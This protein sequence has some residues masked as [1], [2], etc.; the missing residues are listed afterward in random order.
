[1]SRSRSKF[2]DSFYN[3]VHRPSCTLDT[4]PPRSSPWIAAC[5]ASTRLGSPFFNSSAA[6]ESA[7]AALLFFSYFS[8]HSISSRHGKSIST[9]SSL[10]STGR[11]GCSDSE[12]SF[13][14]SSKCS[15]HLASTWF[16]WLI[17][18]VVLTVV[19]RHSGACKIYESP[20]YSDVAQPRLKPLRR[21]A[22]SFSEQTPLF[23][24]G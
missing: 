5:N 11:V 19:E 18:L 1:M 3:P 21:G 12:P 24:P 20:E 17:A 15:F 8:A 22:L 13:K 16:L 9:P 10:K 14:C 7:P 23:C 4:I 2:L 6:I